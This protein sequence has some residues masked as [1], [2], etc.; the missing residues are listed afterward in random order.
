[1][2]TGWLD[3]FVK[4]FFNASPMWV[5]ERKIWKP[6]DVDLVDRRSHSRDASEARRSNRHSRSSRS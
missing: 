2:K 6:T 3:D 4:W 1:M 5:D